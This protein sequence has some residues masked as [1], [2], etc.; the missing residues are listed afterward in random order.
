MKSKSRLFS[1]F[2]IG[3]FL[4]SLV[5]SPYVLDFTLTPRL[6][7]I[8][9][10]LFLSFFLWYKINSLQRVKLDFIVLAYIF[11]ILFNCLSGLWANTPTESIFESAKLI[12][13][14]SVFLLSYYLFKSDRESALTILAKIS[15]VIV[16]VEFALVSFQ[17]SYLSEFSKEAMYNVYGAN[18]HKN[19]LSSYLYISLFFLLVGLFRMKK[20][21]K[22][23]TVAALILNL[24]II[25]ITQTK[26]VWI[27]LAV[28]GLLLF[29][30]L[31]YKRTKF[32]INFKWCLI[33][34]ILLANIFFIWVQ[35]R[36]IEKGLAFNM[37]QIKNDQTDGKKELD[38]ERLQLWS[39]TYEMIYDHPLIGVGAGNWQIH[40]P[41]A[42]LK[43]MYRAED[44]NFT[45]QRP[46]NDIL[47]I[48]AE[49]GF[50][51]LN[52]FLFFIFSIVLLL[53]KSLKAVIDNRTSI[54]LLLCVITIIG[55]FT[56]AFF[57]FPKERIEHLIWI[58]IVFGFAY[59]LIKENNELKTLVEF[60]ISAM[61]FVL[62]ELILIMV[63]TVGFY[64]YCGEYYSRKMYDQKK[65]NNNLGVIREAK[66]ALNFTYSID[67]TSLPI[68]W[69][70]GNSYAIL[71][72]FMQAKTDLLKAYHLNPYNRNVI[73][74]LASA[75]VNTNQPDS[76]EYYYLET[77]RISS[78]FDDPKL[79]LAAIYFNQKRFEKADSC[80]KT[81]LHDSERRT[82]YQTMVNAFLRK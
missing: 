82:K 16:F 9:I 47:W 32:K 53:V 72:N 28:S 64:R 79:N 17:L 27:A 63:F 6:I 49:T 3:I 42:T 37:E 35:P 76:A 34:C 29:F 22:W 19:L 67:P 70:T 51:G 20:T 52:L 59:Y 81:L 71:G 45:F 77:I 5:Y 18:S 75:Y 57:D 78:R 44:L 60:K 61:Q 31:L 12:I 30:L 13:A 55:F 39:K 74:D 33:V 25:I 4:S 50:V 54:E 46:H 40:F 7:F 80:L 11:Y 62:M 36:I 24:G 41:D 66:K 8:S 73:N 1:I 43:G 10:T 15:V 14:L 2:F 69:Y 48:I 21:W 26:A 56:A 58:N 23:L 38:N 68:K 65:Q